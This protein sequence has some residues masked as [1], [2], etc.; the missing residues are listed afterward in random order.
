MS[1]EESR[2]ED[3]KEEYKKERKQ[4]IVHLTLFVITIITTTI[5][6]TEWI[7]SRSPFYGPGVTWQ[8]LMDGLSFS[9]PFLTILTIHE[10]GHYLTARYYNIKATLPYYIPFIPVFL[11]IGTLG[12]VI[13]IKEKVNTKK[14]HF[15]IG[16]AGPLAGFVAALVVLF[17][18]F[19]HLPE[20]EYIYKI[21]PEYEY[22]GKDYDQYVY[23][24][25]TTVLKSE[26]EEISDNPRI[27]HLP[28]TVTFGPRGANISLGTNLTFMFFENFIADPDLLPNH[29]EIMH[30][31]WLFAGF[32]ALFFTALNLIPVG[33]LDGG[34]V[35]YG[36]FGAKK[37]SIIAGLIFIAFVLYAGIG[38][39]NPYTTEF[40]DMLITVLVYLFFLYL[41]FSRMSPNVTDRLLIAV[42][43]LGI[44]YFI[45]YFWPFARGYNGWLLFAFIVGRF[46]GVYHPSSP[47]EEPLDTNRKILGWI[48]LIVFVIS[49][50]PKPLIVEGI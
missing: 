16:L 34:H 35:I 9:I 1:T 41:I 22:F 48:T 8:D 4:K 17:Y 46:L 49:F 23:N 5:S 42:I 11:S 50:S 24:T 30:Y 20:P 21:H 10:F 44:Q 14:Q 3:Q 45:V 15:D 12:A 39:V 47:V 27:E 13:R 37:H 19:T 38:I 26:L 32:L 2:T 28:D 18:G 29:Y 7:Y 40:P 33:Q 25:D 43:V 31:P 6:G 36:L